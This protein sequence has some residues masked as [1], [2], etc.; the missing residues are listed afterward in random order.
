MPIRSVTPT[1]RLKALRKAVRVGIDDLEAGRYKAFGSF[2][3]L[4]RYLG[5][6]TDKVLTK[7]RTSRARG[8]PK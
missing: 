7:H 6:M 5:K 4:D 2:A 8:R 1:A 3:D